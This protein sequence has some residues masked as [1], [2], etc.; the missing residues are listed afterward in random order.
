MT[1][2]GLDPLVTGQNGF[3]RMAGRSATLQ[4]VE[5]GTLPDALVCCNDEVAVGALAALW[6]SGVR[7]PEGVS[8]ASIGGTQGSAAFDLTTMRLPLV[9]LGARA[10]RAIMAIDDPTDPLPT[11]ELVVRGTTRRGRT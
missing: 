2:R 7:V 6:S 3:D 1:E 9:E 8:V 10:G 4:L 5:G 11:H